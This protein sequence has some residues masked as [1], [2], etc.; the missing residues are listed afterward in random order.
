MSSTARRIA[1]FIM[2]CFALGTTRCALASQIPEYRVKAAFLFNFSQFVSWPPRA[3]SSAGAPLVIA[4]LGD[5]PF[6]SDLDAIVSGER[7]DGH[8]LVV[9]LYSDVS[10]VDRCHILFITRSE[11]SQLP[12]ILRA[13]RGRAILTVSDINGSA[14]NGVM[15]DLVTQNSRIRMHVNVAAARASGLAISAQLLRLAQIIGPKVD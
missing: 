1:I 4:V 10:Q 3:F 5:N 13:L 12:E 9:R 14:R 15:I 8:P 7:V 6:G 11:T 2:L